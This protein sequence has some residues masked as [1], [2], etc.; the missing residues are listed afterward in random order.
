VRADGKLSRM[1]TH[2]HVAFNVFEPSASLV[3]EIRGGS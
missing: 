1:D 3:T 2:V